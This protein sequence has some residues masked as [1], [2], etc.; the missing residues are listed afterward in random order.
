MNKL[1]KRF[2]QFKTRLRKLVYWHVLPRYDSIHADIS[3]RK[4]NKRSRKQGGLIKV[5]FIVQVPEFWNKEAPVYEAML[6]DERYDPWLVVVPAYSEITRTW[7]AYGAELAFFRHRYP[8]ANIL[9]SAELSEDFRKLKK[10]RFDYIFFQRCWEAYLPKKLRTRCVL[11]YAKTCYIPYA[12]HC[13]KP[14]P[15]YYLTRFFSSLSIMFCCSESQ[16][17]SFQPSGLRKTVFLGYPCLDGI[18]RTVERED[19]VRLLWTPRW[20]PNPRYGGTTFFAY[21]DRFFDLAEQHPELEIVFRPHPLTFE[22][23]VSTGQMTEEEVHVYQARC[24]AAGIRFDRNANIDDTLAGIDILLS[25]FS[26]ILI[27]A[28]LFGKAIIYCGG[29]A[30]AEPDE[31]M[32]RVLRCVYPAESWDDVNSTILQL[33][34]QIDPLRESRR[35]LAAQLDT[36]HRNSTAAV[37][38]Y[39]KDEADNSHKR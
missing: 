22:N 19:R 17:L 16:R 23:A 38:Q 4:L 33:M 5:G 25:D 31:T 27:D 11:R 3:I 8:A 37:L 28:A 29:K 14:Y 18:R 6:Q 32:D 39:L 2:N 10:A 20:S 24:A 21:K 9:T 13:F 1:I 26:S 15:T 12:F 35:S 34:Q 36:E 30:E 7:G